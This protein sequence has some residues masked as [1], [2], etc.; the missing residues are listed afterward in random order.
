MPHAGSPLD[1]S[2]V[3]DALSS[4]DPAAAGGAA[5]AV[6]ASAAAAVVAKAARAAGQPGLAAQADALTGRLAA[7]V[8]D[9]VSAYAA[10]LSALD[11]VAEGGGSG[12]R[13]L[14]LGQLLQRAAAVPLAVAEA[15]ADVAVLAGQI[16]D[17][18]DPKLGNDAV[19]AG[20]L[21]AGAARA[22]AFLVEVNL[23]LRPDDD[24][25]ARARAA[26]AAAAGAV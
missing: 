16:A 17:T 20:M 9:D 5:A 23:A 11:G 14:R 15:S 22:A 4:G 10:A 19:A 2:G 8:A 1:I 13:D 3:I 26:A 24:R 6:A 18:G 25:V 21:A 12:A 7:L